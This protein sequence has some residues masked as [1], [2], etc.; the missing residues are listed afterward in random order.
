M[1]CRAE[2]VLREGLNNVWEASGLTRSPWRGEDH[3]PVTLMACRGAAPQSSVSCREG[4][5]TVSLFFN[6][7]RTR[8]FACVCV[9]LRS[10]LGRFSMNHMPNT[11]PLT[12]CAPCAPPARAAP[13]R[14][15]LTREAPSFSFSHQQ[16]QRLLLLC[17]LAAPLAL[18]QC[19]SSSAGYCG[20]D[21]RYYYCCSSGREY[22]R[23][24][25]G[26]L[27]SFPAPARFSPPPHPPP[28]RPDINLPVPSP[29][30][31]SH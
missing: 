20:S 19:S 12:P 1:F 10:R 11:P 2:R 28:R 4:M 13:L 16:M 29:Q 5:E 18:A 7:I 8:A 15:A 14:R 22:C 27:R 3:L 9:R 6:I 21:S 24:G 17:A 23:P 26:A 31:P 25:I 30:R